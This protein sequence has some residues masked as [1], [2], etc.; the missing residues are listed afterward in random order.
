MLLTCICIILNGKGG[1]FATDI[2]ACAIF[3]TSIVLETISVIAFGFLVL[4]NE[5]AKNLIIYV[6]FCYF[7]LGLML[8]NATR[9]LCITFCIL[10]NLPPLKYYKLWRR[11]DVL[12]L[13]KCFCWTSLH[14]DTLPCDQWVDARKRFFVAVLNGLVL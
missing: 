9:K 14:L 12:I 7:P 2:V 5:H 3:S 6:W 4:Y 10:Y 11:K 13:E 8:G 1:N